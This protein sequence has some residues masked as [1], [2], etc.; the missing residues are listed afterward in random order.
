MKLY[1]YMNNKSTDASVDLEYVTN[2]NIEELTSNF[3]D[4]NSLRIRYTSNNY[5]I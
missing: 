1:I 4:S 3:K 2:E 5:A